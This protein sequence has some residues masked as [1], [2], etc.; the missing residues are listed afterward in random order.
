MFIKQNELEVLSLDVS[1]NV[2]ENQTYECESNAK[3]EFGIDKRESNVLSFELYV[4]FYCQTV[5]E[6]IVTAKFRKSCSF[7]TTEDKGGDSDTIKGFLNTFTHEIESYLRANIRNRLIRNHQD[8]ILMPVDVD[9]VIRDVIT[10]LETE[11]YY[12]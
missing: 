5:L 12:N 6:T 1:S 7:N 10:K 11:G 8:H 2:T 9:K 3:V 4:S